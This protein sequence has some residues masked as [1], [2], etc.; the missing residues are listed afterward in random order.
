MPQ[1]APAR[2]NDGFRRL[3]GLL[4]NHFQD[5][6]G[7]VRHMVENPPSFRLVADSQLVGL[8]SDY[9]HRARM[10]QTEGFAPL[11]PSQ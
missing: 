10:G 2:L 11:Q 5:D 4:F 8:R 3:L 9:R 1:P 6:D 7:L